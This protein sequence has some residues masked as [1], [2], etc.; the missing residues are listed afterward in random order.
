[1]IKIRMT[2]MHAGGCAVR[3]LYANEIG[4]RGQTIQEQ[5]EDFTTRFRWLMTGAMREPRGRT[6]LVGAMITRPERE[7]S[8]AGIFFFFDGGYA[9]MCGSA[10]FSVGRILFEQH[11]SRDQLEVDTLRGPIAISSGVRK[12]TPIISF[13]NDDVI[14]FALDR[15]VSFCGQ[16]LSY[17]IAYGGN[18]FAIVDC[19]QLGLTLDLQNKKKIVDIAMELFPVIT[20]QP[21]PIHPLRF[22]REQVNEIMFVETTPPGSHTYRSVIVYGNRILDH[23]P[24]GTGSCARMANLWSRN[25]LSVGDAFT[26]QSLFGTEFYGEVLD[27]RNVGDTEVLRCRLSASP[28]KTGEGFLL[29]DKTDPLYSGIPE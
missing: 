8:C 20:A 11:S 13:I 2:D 22:S 27:V 17:D 14:S 10:L 16:E 6:N 26:H 3:V 19:E 4:L 18:S 23:A 5:A 7:D 24:C 15:K 12:D 9:A 28:Q 29:F 21:A 1:M 25:M